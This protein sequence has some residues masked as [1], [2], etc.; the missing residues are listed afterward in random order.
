MER[1]ACV[2][3]DGARSGWIAVWEADDALAFA[4]Y[5]TVAES[6]QRITAGT[7]GSLPTVVERGTCGLRMAI[8]Y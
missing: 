2:G 5:A 7:A 8:Y 6:A 3:V 1:H 4:Y